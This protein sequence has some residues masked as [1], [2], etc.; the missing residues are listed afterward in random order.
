V[1][2]E[3][4]ERRVADPVEDDDLERRAHRLLARG[5]DAGRGEPDEDRDE[6]GEQG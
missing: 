2:G 1:L 4:R 3:P 6:N 5:R